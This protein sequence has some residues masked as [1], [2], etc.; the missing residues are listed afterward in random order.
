[1]GLKLGCSLISQK[2]FIRLRVLRKYEVTGSGRRLPIEELHNFY[3]SP[4]TIRMIKSRWDEVGMACSM[5][6]EKGNA[7]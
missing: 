2:A 7:Y 3:P 1:M 6:G 4:G 5:D